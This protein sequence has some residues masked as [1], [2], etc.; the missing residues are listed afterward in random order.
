MG[1]KKLRSQN[2]IHM[3]IFYDTETSGINV[4]FDQILQFA[5]ILTDEHFV[6][7]DRLEIRC[8]ILSWVIPSP[9]AMLVTRTSGSAIKD[10]SL[11]NFYEMMS[12]IYKKL[13]FNIRL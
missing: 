13:N 7:I 4:A 10:K 3:F 12:V 1:V 2:R 9:I 6:E 8:Q 11:P 5:A